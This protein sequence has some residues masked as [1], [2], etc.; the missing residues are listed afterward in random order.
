MDETTTVAWTHLQE[1][2]LHASQD[3]QHDM[4]A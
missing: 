2:H 4:S 1:S 3:K